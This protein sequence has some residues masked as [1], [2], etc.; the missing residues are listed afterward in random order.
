MRISSQHK[1]NIL[2]YVSVVS[3]SIHCSTSDLV[4]CSLWFIFYLKSGNS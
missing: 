2:G 3:I 4:P 1:E